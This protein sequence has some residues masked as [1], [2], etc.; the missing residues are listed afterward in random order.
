[1]CISKNQVFTKLSKFSDQ[2]LGT[3]FG[4]D[5]FSA[6]DNS[7]R[8]PDPTVILK[9][10]AQKDSIKFDDE[11]FFLVGY[12]KLSKISSMNIGILRENAVVKIRLRTA[13]VVVHVILYLQLSR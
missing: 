1:M 12:S 7:S 3:F 13:L 10:H 5:F 8:I 6:G 2:K 9:L 11:L 4:C